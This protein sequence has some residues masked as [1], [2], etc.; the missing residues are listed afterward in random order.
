MLAYGCCLQDAL[1]A[2]L[3]ELLEQKS[4]WRDLLLLGLA[5]VGRGGQGDVGQRIRDEIL[6]VQ[7]RNSAKVTCTLLLAEHELVYR[8]SAVFLLL[9]IARSA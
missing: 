4:E 1:T 2:L 7:S 6:Y 3:A 5:A 8:A 9:V